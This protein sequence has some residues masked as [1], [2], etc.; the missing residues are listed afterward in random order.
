[1]LARGGHVHNRFLF[2]D[3]ICC[4]A[5]LGHDDHFV[6]VFHL[7]ASIDNDYGYHQRIA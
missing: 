2:D 5:H 6:V 3:I 1:V 7:N 4:F